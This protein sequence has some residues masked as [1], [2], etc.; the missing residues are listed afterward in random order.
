MTKITIIS[1]EN[2]KELNHYKIGDFIVS[3]YYRYRGNNSYSIL[4][5]DD[6]TKTKKNFIA[7]GIKCIIGKEHV[8]IRKNDIICFE[9]GT[10]YEDYVRK[11]T[12]SEKKFYRKYIAP[13]IKLKLGVK[14]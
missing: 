12:E 11:A 13:L 5:I 7:H 6:I 1:P 2:P 4:K 10:I 9:I 3:E 8:W 14:K